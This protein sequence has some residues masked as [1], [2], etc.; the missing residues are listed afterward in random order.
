MR[1]KFVN[2]NIKSDRGQNRTL[3]NPVLV[4]EVPLFVWMQDVLCVRQDDMEM[5]RKLGNH[6]W[7]SLYMRSKI[8]ISIEVNEDR[9]STLVEIYNSG[10]YKS[11]QWARC[12]MALSYR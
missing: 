4:D 1:R 10:Y 3:W 5:M 6:G 2:I 11:A 12:A 8:H 9:T 7:M